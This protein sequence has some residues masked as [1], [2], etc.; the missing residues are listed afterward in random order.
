MQDKSMFV[1]LFVI[2]SQPNSF[3]V[4]SIKI[5]VRVYVPKN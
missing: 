1:L 4:I 5:Y 2:S 3:C